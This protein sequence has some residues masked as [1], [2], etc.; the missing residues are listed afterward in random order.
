MPILPAPVTL[1]C[2]RGYDPFEDTERDTALRGLCKL[3]RCFRG[4]DPFE[5]TESSSVGAGLATFFNVSGATIRLRI[6]KVV[7]RHR[8]SEKEH[9]FQ[10]LRSV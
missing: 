9:L 8:A 7:Q 2:F 1:E 6:L 3:S 4:Y 10:G 5:D